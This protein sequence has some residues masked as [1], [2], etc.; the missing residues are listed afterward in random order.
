[1][2]APAFVAMN[3]LDGSVVRRFASTDEVAV[4]VVDCV[5]SDVAEDA[6][7]V[8]V[9]G[10]PL[11]DSDAEG[12]IRGVDL[13][14]TNQTAR[15]GLR[16][17]RASVLELTAAQEA[18]LRT[19]LDALGRVTDRMRAFIDQAEWRGGTVPFTSMVRFL[20]APR[21]GAGPYAVRTRLKLSDGPGALQVVV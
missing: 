2:N 14:A 15:L 10:H 16:L 20:G 13:V 19:A 4:Y 9:E 1:M 12:I 7:V 11:A 5:L 17:G 3:R 8:T 21:D 6:E 18:E